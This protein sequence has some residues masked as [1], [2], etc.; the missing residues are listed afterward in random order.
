MSFSHMVSL[1]LP[2]GTWVASQHDISLEMLFLIFFFNLYLFFYLQQRTMLVLSL[3][4]GLLS[5]SYAFCPLY[6][7]EIRTEVVLPI[8]TLLGLMVQV[9]FMDTQIWYAIF[10][11]LVGGIYGACRRLGEVSN[12]DQYPTSLS[13]AYVKLFQFNP[14]KLP[15]FVNLSCISSVFLDTVLLLC[16]L[17]YKGT[18]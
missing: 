13:L 5:F 16:G 12:T 15:F 11:T 4:F 2:F 17:L 18:K 6:C 1:S 3:H 10:S 14:V 8:L 9:Y 7:L